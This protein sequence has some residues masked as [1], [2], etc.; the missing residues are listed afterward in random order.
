[1]RSTTVRL[2][3]LCLTSLVI[4][5]CDAGKHVAP[6]VDDAFLS[7]S[8]SPSL[9]APSNLTSTTTSPYV[10]TVSWQDNSKNETGFELQRST[11]GSSGSFTAIATPGVGAVAYSDQGLTPESQYCYKVRAFRRAG[12]NTAYS[13]FSN[14]QCS[15]TASD[16]PTN[17]LAI[18]ANS[19]TISIT[20]TDNSTTESGFRVE[21]SVDN[22]ATWTV[23]TETSP[24]ETQRYEYGVIPESSRHC[25][26]VRTLHGSVATSPSNTDCTVPP[27]APTNLTA[28]VVDQSIVISWKDNSSV[29]DGYEVRRSGAS[30]NV[31]TILPA[32]ATTYTDPAPTPEVWYFYTV[33]AREH[34]GY[35]DQSNFVQAAVASGPPASPSQ[36]QAY[37]VSSSV[38]GIYWTNNAV[39][40]TGFRV[41]RSTDGGASWA[42]A[43]VADADYRF[44]SDAN[45]PADQRLCYRVFAVNAKGESAP[46]NTDC[47]ALPASPASITA[48]AVDDQSIDITWTGGPAVKDGYPVRDGYIV[49]RL[50]YVC[51]DFDYCD[52]EYE[53]IAYPSADATSF[54]D[55]Y[56]GSDT[57]YWYFVVATNDGGTSDASDQVSATTLP[58]PSITA[59][60]VKTRVRPSAVDL[61]MAASRALNKIG[62]T[63]A[64]QRRGMHTPSLKKSSPRPS[65]RRTR[66]P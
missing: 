26:R 36:A 13:A 45:Q 64:S 23:L 51:W 24:N 5:A 53:P 50:D 15:T 34:G 38:A 63:R 20:W 17:L 43:G 29:E 65:T 66:S 46:S 52:Y 11:T 16:A 39:T 9:D 32:N 56:L 14:V 62:S 27:A 22:G 28:A 30:G 42:T 61:R 37:P 10:I 6:N 8:A 35:S 54:R 60:M 33:V 19:S 49:F 40:E 48:T 21:R 44:F 31:V 4:A 2:V 3:S 18:P 59:N 55:T 7:L 58:A 57:E 1:M 41:E 12:N 25:Y 47:T